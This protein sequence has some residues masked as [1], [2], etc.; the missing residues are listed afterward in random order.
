MTPPCGE[1]RLPAGLASLAII[2]TILRL[3]LHLPAGSHTQWV[4]ADTSG[5]AVLVGDALDVMCGVVTSSAIC[6]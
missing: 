4:T 1:E 2:K 5:R 6:V 3:P